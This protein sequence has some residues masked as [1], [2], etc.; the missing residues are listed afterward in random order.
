MT[1]EDNPTNAKKIKFPVVLLLL[2]VVITLLGF[3]FIESEHR[4]ME[5]NDIETLK[6]STNY[7]EETVKTYP[8][9]TSKDFRLKLIEAQDEYRA[10]L[11]DIV[12]TCKVTDFEDLMQHDI[13]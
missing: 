8:G 3:L 6:S 9:Q 1:P 4:K 10:A 12:M 13:R 2:A 7:G 11:N 5:M